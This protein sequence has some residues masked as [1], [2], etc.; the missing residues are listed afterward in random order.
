MDSKLNANEK[1]YTMRRDKPNERNF[2]RLRPR[3]LKQRTYQRQ[4]IE[5]SKHEQLHIHPYV[6]CVWILKFKETRIWWKRRR[7]RSQKNRWIW[8]KMK[9]FD[10]WICSY[11]Y[12]FSVFNW[13]E[14]RNGEFFLIFSK[15]FETSIRWH[16]MY[17]LDNVRS[18]KVNGWMVDGG[19]FLCIMCTNIACNTNIRKIRLLVCHF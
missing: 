13:K 11:T 17:H 8:R 18:C 10:V 5:D 9:L 14:M 16:K 1:Y 6:L 15:W 12:I 3:E 19:H 7:R 2:S 4:W